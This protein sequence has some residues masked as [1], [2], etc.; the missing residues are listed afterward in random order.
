MPSMMPL[1]I[2]GAAPRTTTN[3]IAF[4]LRLKST[5]ASGYHATD[6]IVWSPVIMDPTPARRTRERATAMPRT[7]PITIASAKPTAARRRVTQAELLRS[8]RSCASWLTT[9]N[10]D[11]TMYSGFQPVH[12]TTCQAPKNSPTASSFG[13]AAAQ[14]DAA[15]PGPRR[16]MSARA[17]DSMASAVTVAICYLGTEPVGDRGG[18]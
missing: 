12:T 9:V 18:E 14:S 1:A 6:G 15:R 13:Q 3:K 8:V 5:S 7:P 4:W 2:D 11:G 10:G 17:G 16:L